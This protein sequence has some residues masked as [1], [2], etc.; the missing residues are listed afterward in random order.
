MRFGTFENEYE[1]LIGSAAHPKYKR[2]LYGAVGTLVV[3]SLMLAMLGG[4][5]TAA[6]TPTLA[7]TVAA[8]APEAVS[9]ELVDAT[10]V[11]TTEAVE[12]CYTATQFDFIYNILSFGIACMG[13]STIF[14]FFQFSRVKTEYQNSIVVSSLVV[15]IACYHYIRI[16]NSFNEAY[17]SADGVVTATGIPFNNA[18]R[19]VDWLLTV[20][21]LLMEIILVTELEGPEKQAKCLQLGSAAALMILLGYPGELT[22]GSTR[23]MFWALAMCP[24]LFIV[25]SLLIGLNDAIKAST[26]ADVRSG[27]HTACWVTVISWCTYPI[28][29][30]FPLV[31]LTGFTAHTAVQVGYTVAD[32]VSKPVLGL[33]V[34][35]VAMLHG[36]AS[37]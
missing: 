16:F 9:A 7:T 3:G 14:F 27:L 34:W 20:P 23:W 37:A 31:G 19:Y 30:I 36:K 5:S 18:Y 4:S 32:I 26:D 33:V 12:E 24:F 10:P 35:N 11:V 1:P 13:S 22:D 6:V 28:V 15:L 29:Y 21:L 8:V 17:V 25:Y 2:Y